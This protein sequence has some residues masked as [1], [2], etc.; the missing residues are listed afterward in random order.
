MTTNIERAV[1][2]VR[3]E[4]DISYGELNGTVEDAVQALSD[5]GLLRVN[6]PAPQVIRTVE[7][8]QALDPETVLGVWNP[9]LD[10]GCIFLTAGELVREPTDPRIRWAVIATA[11]Q[12]RAARKALE[13]A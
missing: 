12:V 2:I 8:L 6:I 7:E 11:E 4:L 3:R 9:A 1:N 10:M 13:E 5:V